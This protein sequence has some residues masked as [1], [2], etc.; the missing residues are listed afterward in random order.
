[1]VFDY[2]WK[3]PN[4]EAAF[5]TFEE[6]SEEVSSG[7]EPSIAEEDETTDQWFIDDDGALVRSHVVPRNKLFVPRQADPN[8]PVEYSSI[9]P[10]R[11]THSP[12]PRWNSA[13]PH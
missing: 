2:S 6:Q 11:H 5:P 4:F 12:T 7:Y 13:E 1:M 3:V 10:I 8:L 9:M